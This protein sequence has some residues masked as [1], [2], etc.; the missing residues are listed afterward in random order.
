MDDHTYLFSAVAAS[1]KK[2][3]WEPLLLHF[4]GSSLS[5]YGVIFTSIAAIAASVSACS[6]ITQNADVIKHNKLSVQPYFGIW[7]DE[8]GAK[9]HPIG[10]YLYN[11]GLAAC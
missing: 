4:K 5:D 7:F 3:S 2:K 6:A 9:K 11:S 8:E 1:W 10:W